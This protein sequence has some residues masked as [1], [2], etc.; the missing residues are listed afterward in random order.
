MFSTNKNLKNVVGKKSFC[1]AFVPLSLSLSLLFVETCVYLGEAVVESPD[2]PLAWASGMRV[3]RRSLQEGGVAS[4]IDESE[5]F[6]GNT[7]HRMA[8][9][10]RGSQLEAS[11]AQAGTSVVLALASR[12]LTPGTPSL[13]AG[14]R[15]QH[16][17][18]ARTSERLH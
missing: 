10:P 5:A 12:I 18:R 15:G 2:P 8:A 17:L 13:T 9:S 16:D 1:V 7:R 14:R 4:Y 3:H 6:S 11:S